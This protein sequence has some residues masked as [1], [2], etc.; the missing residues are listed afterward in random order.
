MPLKLFGPSNIFNA[1]AV[2]GS[3]NYRSAVIDMLCMDVA[4]LELQWSGN[5]V[6]T[7]S[8]DGSIN[9][10]TWYPTG[11]AVNNPTGA[12]ASDNSLINLSGIGYRYLSLSYINSSGSGVLTVTATAKGLGA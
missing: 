9:G 11:T 2:T 1:Q 10:V 12:A 8:V 6:G 5:P 3:T 7:L 4:A